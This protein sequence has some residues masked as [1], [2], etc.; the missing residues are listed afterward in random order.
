M[1]CI[2]IDFGGT[3][4]KLALIQNGKIRKYLSFPANSENG[5]LPGLPIVKK[6][7]IELMGGESM[8]TCKGVGVALPG[9]VNP[10]KMQL[11]EIYGK[12]E[13]ALGF[14]LSEW[15]ERELGLPMRMEMDSKAALLGEM[16]FGCA[17]G[18]KDALMVIM[19]TGVGTA[20]AIN[21]KILESHNFQAGALGS[22]LVIE[23][24]GR[25][26]T[27]GGRGCLE[28][29]TGGWAVS[30]MILEH[31]DYKK[32]GLA[33]EK[34]ADYHS[35][36]K[37]AC[38]EDPIA[39]EILKEVTSA[40]KAGIISLIHAY[41]PEV[42]ILSGGVIKFGS[43]LIEPVVKD[44]NDVIWNSGNPVQV[45]LAEHPDESVLLGLYAL[46]KE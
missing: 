9:I 18:A 26:C 31:P 24:D 44:L 19:G 29:Y 3:N 32:S 16:H 6:K 43:L 45:R 4:I 27:C 33:S 46:W 13:D 10:K 41:D 11:T 40:L 37:W 17:K 30:R 5:L 15:F 14:D 7:V 8:D 42:V 38:K 39:C 23:P 1:Q 25:R 2:G 36:K 34:R 20:A 12:Y 28:A 21:G 35:L 22:H